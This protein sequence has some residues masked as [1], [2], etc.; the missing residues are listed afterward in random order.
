MKQKT[1]THPEFEEILCLGEAETDDMTIRG[2]YSGRSMHGATCLAVVV[3]G[4]G[5]ATWAVFDI[6]VGLGRVEDGAGEDYI[7][8]FRDARTDQLGSGVVVYWPRVALIE[9]GAA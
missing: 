5:A 1:I 2:D 6:A 8:Y 4:G 9:D 7:D 3:P